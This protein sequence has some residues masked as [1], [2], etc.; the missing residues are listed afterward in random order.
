M[1]YLYRFFELMV[2]AIGMTF[3]L[4]VIIYIIRTRFNPFSFNALELM[5]STSISMIWIGI[6]VGL[7]YKRFGALLSWLGVLLFMLT[8]YWVSGSW[9]S[10]WLLV[11]LALP[12]SLYIASDRFK[13]RLQ[14]P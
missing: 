14:E 12:G 2:Q 10:G 1:R 9:P 6:V 13:S 4:Y 3:S 8:L 7:Q 11:V 5:V